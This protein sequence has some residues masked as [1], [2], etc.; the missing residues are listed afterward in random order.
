[1]WYFDSFILFISHIMIFS[2]VQMTKQ[3][4][5]ELKLENVCTIK[6]A[7][8]IGTLVFNINNKIEECET[9]ID[10]PRNQ[11]Q[12]EYEYK[13]ILGNKFEVELDSQRFNTFANNIKHPDI[14]QYIGY[15]LLRGFEKPLRPNSIQ[16]Y[17]LQFIM[18]LKII[19]SLSYLNYHSQFNYQ[20]MLNVVI[21]TVFSFNEVYCLNIILSNYDLRRKTI[22]SNNIN[23]AIIIGGKVVDYYKIIDITNSES[24]ETWDN[25]RRCIY[26]F[27]SDTQKSLERSYIC[28]LFYY[29]IVTNIILA[30]YGEIY[31]IISKESFILNPLIVISSTFTFIFLNTLIFFRLYFGS[32]FNET[33]EECQDQVE[34]IIG[35]YQD[36][37]QMYDYNFT[38][39]G[40]TKNDYLKIL[41]DQED[42]EVSAQK[43]EDGAVSQ[44]ADEMK[45]NRSISKSRQLDQEKCASQL[46][47]EVNYYTCYDIMISKFMYLSEYYI[48]K[49]IEFQGKLY[50]KEQEKILQ[51]KMMLNC[52]KSFK[53]IKQ[54]IIVDAKLQC[55]Q[56]FNIVRL[57]F[58]DTLFTICL[59]LLT[60]LPQI[61]TKFIEQFKFMEGGK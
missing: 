56:A 57:D 45:S 53:R 51:Q 58:K 11:I 21:I 47:Q 54:Q 2:M 52:L 13:R 18:F 22:M 7:N 3:N 43:R 30:A 28:L 32:K 55:Y 20:D 34:N 29:L 8:N 10:I 14:Q 61:I 19:C 4:S 59:G 36:L 48:D 46:E 50:T 24:I 25:S 26:E 44:N 37:I 6:Q 39:R 9:L 31:I 49:K 16:Y 5:F 12:W 38:Q 35:I 42:E 23:N 40:I 17:T 15:Q 41:E 60:L 33:F 27:F 1:M